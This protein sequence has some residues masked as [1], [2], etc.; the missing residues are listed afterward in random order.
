MFGAALV[1]VR[2]L[3]P[4]RGQRRAALLL[5]LFA[6]MPASAIVAWTGWGGK[7]RQYSFDFISGEMWSGQYLWGYL[8]TGIAVFLMPLVL[9][10]VERWRTERR[11]RTLALSALGALLVCWLQPW[12][13]GTLA[14]IVVGV[15]LLRWWRRGERP[16]PAL[17]GDPG[18]GRRGRDLLLHA[19]ADRSRVGARGRVERRG[20]PGHAGAGRGGRSC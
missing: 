6:V 17:R 2:R 18:R 1:Y 10:G 4:A 20:Q 3:L 5:V 7:L 13:G 14:L 19:V 8:M 12:Q 16:D 9:L 11:P 15:E